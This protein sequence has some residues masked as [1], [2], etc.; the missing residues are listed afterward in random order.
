MVI[1]I[2]SSVKY[3]QVPLNLLSISTIPWSRLNILENKIKISLCLKLRVWTVS[4]TLSTLASERFWEGHCQWNSHLHNM[5]ISN[6]LPCRVCMEGEVTSIH[7]ICSYRN[8]QAIKF[9]MFESEILNLSVLEEVTIGK[10]R[11]PSAWRLPST[12][13]LSFI[14]Y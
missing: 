13:S 4:K 14:R 5:G 1:N 8:L 2:Y 11:G 12:K 3:N 9:R 10:L 6:N 7:V